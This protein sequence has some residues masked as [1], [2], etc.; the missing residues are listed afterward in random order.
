MGEVVEFIFCVYCIIYDKLLITF[1]PLWIS[2]NTYLGLYNC[3]YLVFAYIL[4]LYSINKLQISKCISKDCINK[5]TPLAGF[6]VK[7]KISP[8]NNN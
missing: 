5:F 7:S 4:S 2:R 6:P 8:S 1:K 3:C